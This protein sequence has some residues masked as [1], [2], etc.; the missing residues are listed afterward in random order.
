MTD[1]TI[2]LAEAPVGARVVREGEVW[3]RKPDICT[4][5]LVTLSGLDSDGDEK[6]CHVP[7]RTRVLL[8]EGDEPVGPRDCWNRHVWDPARRI[9]MRTDGERF[10]AASDR[11][12]PIVAPDQQQPMSLREV[13]RELDL[14]RWEVDGEEIVG[15]HGRVI[16][17]TQVTDAERRALAD[18]LTGWTP[19]EPR[20]SAGTIAENAI[21]D[22]YLRQYP[23][24]HKMAQE[25]ANR[26][27]PAIRAAG[28][29][30]VDVQVIAEAIEWLR[31][32]ASGKWDTTW[33]T[34]A[35]ALLDAL[36]AGEPA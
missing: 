28:V 1:L 36:T 30:L 35:R 4:G 17:V 25:H 22:A 34:H 16:K 7:G 13:A 29:A 5:G 10:M 6:V 15:P 20:P 33:R 11:Y 18:Q 24:A 31:R 21:R 8:L 32:D 19:P 14:P 2:T 3:R 9:V 27:V 23:D 12:W 26:S